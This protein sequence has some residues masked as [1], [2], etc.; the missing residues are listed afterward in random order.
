ME[1][2]KK[3]KAKPQYSMGSDVR[4]LLRYAW[5]NARPMFFLYL[6]NIPLQ[7]AV[8]ALAMLLPSR[9]VSLL[10]SG[11]GFER[12]AGEIVLLSLGM[13][14]CAAGSAALYEH[15]GNIYIV[16]PRLA[17]LRDSI[18]KILTTDYPNGEKQDFLL[19]VE[20]RQEVLNSNHQA[21]EESYRIMQRLL[22]AALGLGVYGVV[23]W[24][25][26]PWVLLG[27]AALTALGFLSRRAANNWIFKNQDHWA[28][29]ERKMSYIQE[30]AGDFRFA[31]DVRLFGMSDWLR[32]LY[33][34]FLRLR[35][36]WASKQ[37]W[38][39]FAADAAD[40]VL[41]FLR[42][43]AAYAWLLTGAVNGTIDAASFV[44]YF[45]AVG[46]FSEQF[47]T[48]L[49][50]FSNLHK[51]HLK[52]AS[53]REMLDYPETFCREG[54]RP[55]PQGKDF[56]LTLRHVSYRYP[57]AGKDTIH[58][59]D[60][61]LHPGEKVALVGLNGAGK[62]TLVKLLCG[63]YDPT[64]GEV[65]LNG[66]P[67]TEFNRTDYYTLFSVV[68]QESGIRPSTI[69]VNVSAQ[70]E[71]DREKVQ[72][73]LELAGLWNKVKDLPK[74]MD[75]Y[76]MK[77]IWPD[78]V[79]LSGG[80]TQKLMLAKALYKDGP[81]ILLDEP[82]AA[83]DPIAEAELYEK[84]NGLTQG[85]TSLYI[86][87]RLSSTRFCD[88]VLFLENGDI[89]EEGTHEELIAK[90]GKYYDLYEI[91]SAYYRKNAQ[92]PEGGEGFEAEMA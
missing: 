40:C 60:L 92:L 72:S 18:E 5:K 31:K 9:V 25:L 81:V 83:L 7:A 90:Q 6:V 12:L 69:A 67:I 36:D 30:Q 66:I 4:F 82:T 43:G 3:R 26:S 34:S 88:R 38:V 46:N 59:M 29:Y 53:L 71:P 32:D 52:I 50:E 65:L 13:L 64:E 62:T 91:Q 16:R 77:S 19:K 73:C 89:V 1:P 39:E 20:K 33:Q 17:M 87:H 58:N 48:C 78:A 14:L 27:T 10:E 35:L 28:P 51:M 24:A 76:L 22:T 11:A 85:K 57:G 15:V 47:L 49:T 56:E 37:G 55:L 61:T 74:G 41:T 84:Y 63:L 2:K 68:F 86:S 75:T 42:E 54:G 23:L 79:D 70:E 8:P 80:E 44:L 45:T 21:G